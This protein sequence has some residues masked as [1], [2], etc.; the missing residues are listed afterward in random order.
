MAINR[1]FSIEDGNTASSSIVATRIRDYSDVDL[2]FDSKPTSGE[3][4]KKLDAAAVKQ[5]I[6]I[7]MLTNANEKVF[8]PYFG[9]D[10]R[11]S[12]FELMDATDE[13]SIK[14]NIRN[15]IAHYEPRVTVE[16]IKVS[17]TPDQHSLDVLLVFKIVNSNEIVEFKTSLNRLR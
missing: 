15:V 8:D 4:Y 17:V 2:S 3:I 12:L 6:K 10:L 11:S 1:S 16:N 5:A 7:L 13:E 14:R 9:A